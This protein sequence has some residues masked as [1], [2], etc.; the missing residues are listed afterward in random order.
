MKGFNFTKR[1]YSESTGH[2]FS[3][4]QIEISNEIL[5]VKGEGRGDSR[6]Y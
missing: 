1:L 6:K 2:S 5:R 3:S 4:Q